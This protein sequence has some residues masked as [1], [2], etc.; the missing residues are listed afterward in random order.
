M[1][2]FRRVAD[3]QAFLQ[4]ERVNNREVGFVPTMGALHA[5]HLKLIR[6]SLA[7]NQITVASIFVNPTQFNDPSDLE[8]YPRTPGK[9][10]EKLS[11]VGC[12][13]VFLPTVSEIYPTETASV[14]DIA[15][16]HLATTMEGAHRPGHFDGVAQVVKRLLEIV[17]PSRLYMGQKDYQQQLIVRHLVQWMQIPTRVV[18][19]TTEREEDG[20]AMSSRNV[21]MTP[22][23]RERAALL[24]E[25]LTI[26][27]EQLL[28]GTPIEV[29][30]TAALARLQQPDF[31]PEYFSI[32]DGV[33]LL[34]VQAEAL[35]ALVVACTAVKVGKVRLIDNLILKGRL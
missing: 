4:A 32:V 2:V 1:Y 33:T 8:K 25:T 28:A 27:K 10:L 30:E 11:L 35:P 3:L 14:P 9:D 5:G 22:Q 17:T 6:Q 23:L 19:V 15:L 31:T 13:V 20:L 21:L 7:E 34:P 18:T 16:G 24:Y 26:A 12:Q 29:I